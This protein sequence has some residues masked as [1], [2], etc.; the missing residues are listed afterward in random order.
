[1]PPD[2]VLTLVCPDRRG[3]VFAVSQF[4]IERDCNILDSA[5][6]G[7]PITGTFCMRIHFAAEGTVVDAQR[8]CAEFEQVAQG[9]EMN[10]GI[11][12][13]SI[14]PKVII[15]VSRQDHCLHDLLYRYRIG[16]LKI[17]IPAVVSNHEDARILTES[18]GIDYHCW[19]VTAD[20]KT[21]QEGKLVELIEASGVDFVVLARYMQVLSGEICARLPARIINIH[22]SFLPGFKG[23]RPYQQAHARGVKLIGATAHYVTSDLD[24]GP[25]IEQDVVRVDHS[26]SPNEL[27]TLG[28]DIEKLV[29]ARATQYQAEHR[30]LLTGSRTVVFR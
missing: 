1:M 25:I 26:M 20:N 9:L 22:H 14:K 28:R 21:V 30:V 27:A 15:M 10:W 24:E 16:E 2:F 3:I 5:Q 23:A 17:S 7:D 8:L 18:H 12:D 11:W 13:C 4:L 19:P 29:L 6:F